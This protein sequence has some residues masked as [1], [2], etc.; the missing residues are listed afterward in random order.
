MTNDVKPSMGLVILAGESI[1]PGLALACHYRARQ[2][3]PI[4][5]F[6]YHTA[7]PA[8]SLLPAMRL[9][10]LLNTILPE[11]QVLLPVN[12]SG[13]APHEVHAQIDQW[14]ASQ[15]DI[16][17]VLLSSSGVTG[18][19]LGL[20]GFVGRPRVQI[21]SHDSQQGWQRWQQPETGTGVVTENWTELAA[22]ATDALAL[23]HLLQSQ[24]V[25][26]DKIPSYTAQPGMAL[27]L[28]RL[29]EFGAANGWDWPAT[30]K[31]SGL[32]SAAAPADLFARY[33]A[34]GLIEL[35]IT[36][37]AHRIRITPQ[38][39]ARDKEN[40]AFD[41]AVSCRGQLIL[42]DVKAEE[43]NT[44]NARPAQSLPGQLQR[45]SGLKRQ[46]SALAPRLILFRPCQV[47]TDAER[48]LARACE[49]E[50]IDQTEAPRWFS[51]M[52]S[53]LQVAPLPEPLAEAEKILVDLVS[54]RGRRRV[55]GPES[56][57]TREQEALSGTPVLFDVEKHLDQFCV[58]RG[59]NWV[60]WA[61]R[62]GVFLRLARPASPPAQMPWLIQNSLKRFARVQV[63]ELPNGYEAVFARNDNLLFVLRQ[64]LAGYVNRP[65][66][67]MI[68]IQAAPP[69][70]P[71]LRAKPQPKTAFIAPAGD[72]MDQLDNVLDS[73][74]SPTSSSK[75]RT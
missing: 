20:T 72:L 18:W 49:L 54:F 75:K 34:A 70:P 8:E 44:D 64:A 3:G 51:R 13:L 73:S 55:F 27:P 6:I 52:A 74:V 21:A 45:L 69:T 4:A 17:W 19:N 41:L 32:E 53:L 48:A 1:W 28:R 56:K 26:S 62:T 11:V 39:E 40:L 22:D 68:F 29:T 66:D 42:F 35:G 25:T 23:E 5:V 46:L 2:Q 47:F 43:E 36:N 33:L 16:K 30:F 12:F 50:I 7:Q 9:R 31:D 65:L 67:P 14:I 37:V 58:E 38:P 61:T 60:L 24:F 15:P 59:Q 57:L 63:D 10:Y 71:P